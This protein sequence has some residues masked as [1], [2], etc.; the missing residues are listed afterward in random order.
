[1]VKIKKGDIL[2]CDCKVIIQE[3]SLKEGEH[4]KL[5]SKLA[6]KFPSSM[7]KIRH[8]KKQL[9]CVF[10]SEEDYLVIAN[11]FTQN[12]SGKTVLKEV[13]NTFE[14]V[15]TVCQVGRYATVAMEYNYC[16]K[17]KR[18]NRRIYRIAKRVFKKEKNITLEV[19]K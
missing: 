18:I 5:N 15:R 16:D 6:M 7:D 1:M 9:G 19:I 10:F 13:M 4:S 8:L 14:Y 11:C 17:N 12:E 3:V 2:A